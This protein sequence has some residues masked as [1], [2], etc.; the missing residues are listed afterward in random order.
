MN[1]E[2]INKKLKRRGKV[3]QVIG[4]SK[5]NEQIFYVFATRKDAEK[6]IEK[7]DFLAMHQIV[8]IEVWSMNK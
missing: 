1:K 6:F 7:Q 8:D 4:L 2:Q 5:T 3:F